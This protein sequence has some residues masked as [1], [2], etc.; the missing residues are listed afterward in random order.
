MCKYTFMLIMWFG[1]IFI[2]AD[3]ERMKERERKRIN[4]H[5]AFDDWDSSWTNFYFDWR[6][7]SPKFAE[8]SIF[9]CAQLSHRWHNLIFT[10]SI[11]YTQSNG[12]KKDTEK[13]FKIHHLNQSWSRSRELIKQIEFAQPTNMQPVL[14]A[15]GA[16]SSS[17]GQHCVLWKATWIL[18]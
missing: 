10:L 11:Y 14:L 13:T 15:R 3:G 9:F 6:H 12:G 7:M 5:T 17:R 18:A 4:K 1:N 8:I 2:Y 16:L